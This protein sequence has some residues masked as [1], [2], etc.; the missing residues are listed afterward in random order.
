MMFNMAGQQPMNG[1]DNVGDISGLEVSDSDDE[2]AIVDMKSLGKPG[3]F[4]GE[5]GHWRSWS[6]VFL[7]F[8]A[9][10]SARLQPEMQQA[11]TAANPIINDTLPVKMQRRSRTLYYMLVLQVK[12]KALEIC[13]SVVAGHGYD[14]WRRLRQEYEPDAAGRHMGM[15]MS[16]ITPN[17]GKDTNE[18]P[19][20]LI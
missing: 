16:I 8:T 18:F 19:S 13:R 2:R 14:A 9:A 6:F 10:C 3:I 11:G 12:G 17:F 1:T 7:A 15:L 5:E 4:S 20:H